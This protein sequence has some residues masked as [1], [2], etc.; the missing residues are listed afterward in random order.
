MNFSNDTLK[1]ELANIELNFEF[2]DS[3][4]VALKQ[5]ILDAGYA[6]YYEEVLQLTNKG[7]DEIQLD[8]NG[9][10]LDDL[11]PDE[12]GELKDFLM[13]TADDSDYDE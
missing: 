13:F 2:S 11:D 3:C 7:E 5:Y 6:T 9:L 10:E 12:P 8:L 4:T 1:N